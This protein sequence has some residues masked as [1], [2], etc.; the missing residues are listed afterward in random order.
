MC[1]SE[2]TNFLP[3]LSRIFKDL[4]L[5][6]NPRNYFLISSCFFRFLFFFIIHN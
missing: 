6:F 3:L 4:F 5:C 1:N 2:F